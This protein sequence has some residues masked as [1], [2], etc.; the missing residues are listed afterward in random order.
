MNRQNIMYLY[1]ETENTQ[2]R[3]VG[4]TGEE[5]QFDLAITQTDHFYGKWLVLNLRNNRF[6][7][8]GTDDLEEEGYLEKAFHISPQEANELRQFLHTLFL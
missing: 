2:T 6:A 5:H 1:D 8:I 7:I 3:Y 4:F